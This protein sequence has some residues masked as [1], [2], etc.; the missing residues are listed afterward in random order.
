MNDTPARIEYLTPSTFRT[1]NAGALRNA[2]VANA[3]ALAGHRV[4]IVTADATAEPIDESWTRILD[5][6]VSIVPGGLRSARSNPMR[7]VRRLLEGPT[8][9]GI[10][11]SET[12]DRILVYNPG[13]VVLR[14]VRHYCRIHAVPFTVDATEWLS[15]RDLPGGWLSPYSWW[16]VLHMR[17]LPRRISS[18][19]A[20]STA[21]REHLASAG[22]RV[23]VVPPLHEPAIGPRPPRRGRHRLL[24]SGSALRPGGKDALTLSV[25]AG[26]L[27]SAPELAAL[28]TVDVAGR[29]SGASADFIAR[30]GAMTTV[31]EHGWVSWPRSR[32]LVRAADWLLLI[33]AP[34]ERRLHFGFPSKVTESLVLGT[35]V[36]ANS[37]SDIPATLTSG[38]GVVV[39][40]ASSGDVVSALRT[41]LGESLDPD[42][43]AAEGS[44]RYAPDVWAA[45]L[46]AFIS[47]KID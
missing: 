23:L 19:L 14:R 28:V 38:L 40:S 10:G 42:R 41:A 20:I 31:A 25:L 30:I 3:L 22:A 15:V 6:R 36:I 21:M 18:A 26:A 12:P 8:T 5:P 17:R 1:V 27:E 43:V 44:V 24:V 37:F 13:P 47:E 39:A 35:P 7:K 29:V 34:S 9:Q 16:Y 33:R 4:A 2:G 46:S 32:E 45:R 11:R